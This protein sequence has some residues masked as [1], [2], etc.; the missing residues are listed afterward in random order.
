MLRLLKMI[1]LFP[2]MLVL[3]VVK[4]TD[5][6]TAAKKWVDVTP[7]RSSYYE[8]NTVGAGA[9]W[10]AGAANAA[11]QYKAA[12]SSANIGQMYAGGVKNAGAAKF[13]RKVKDVGVARFGQGVQAAA[14]D[15]AAGVAPMLA[16]IAGLTLSPRQP[17]GSTAN[18]QRVQEVGVALNKKRM[19][20]RAAG[21]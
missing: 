3:G 14:P 6:A 13:D 17:R 1:F 8:A 10:Q 9:A 15:Y 5:A 21:S 2:L 4:V 11:N 12:V 19:A 18:F 16:T 20:L 7:G